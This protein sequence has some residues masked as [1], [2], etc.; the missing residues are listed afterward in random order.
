MRATAVYLRHVPGMFAIDVCFHILVR[1]MLYSTRHLV[2]YD[3]GPGLHLPKK[4][5]ELY[6]STDAGPWVRWMA[7][8]TKYSKSIAWNSHGRMLVTVNL[9]ALIGGRYKQT[10]FFFFLRKRKRKKVYN[11]SVM[12]EAD[13]SGSSQGVRFFFNYFGAVERRGICPF[14][15]RKRR[16]PLFR[17]DAKYFGVVVPC[18]SRWSTTR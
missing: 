11:R 17:L 8:S 12:V 9:C 7:L 10:D 16:N 3:H 5:H 13:A 14:G 15:N 1:S 6:F 4:N 2:A 18:S